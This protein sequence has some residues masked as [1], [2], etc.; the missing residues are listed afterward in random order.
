MLKDAASRLP[1]FK[2][3]IRLSETSGVIWRVSRSIFRRLFLAKEQRRGALIGGAFFVPLTPRNIGSAASGNRDWV[4]TPLSPPLSISGYYFGE[5]QGSFTLTQA[6]LT[7][8]HAVAMPKVSAAKGKRRIFPYFPLCAFLLTS[9]SVC[10]FHLIS[11]FDTLFT[12]SSFLASVIHSFIL[13]S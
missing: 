11:Q 13:L 12:F 4:V 2:L 6:P 3:L 10:C 5:P 7:R 9:Q 1:L 8:R